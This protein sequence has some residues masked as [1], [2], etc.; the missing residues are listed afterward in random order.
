MA[1]VSWA[2]VLIIVE[3]VLIKFPVVSLL[4]DLRITEGQAKST[5]GAMRREVG[6]QIGS[7]QLGHGAYG[8]FGGGRDVEVELL[9]ANLRYPCG[10]WREQLR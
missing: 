10:R 1:A 5:V 9:K 4:M 6:G 7:T 3:T 8:N 2:L